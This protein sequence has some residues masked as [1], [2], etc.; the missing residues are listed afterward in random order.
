MVRMTKLGSLIA[1]LLVVSGCGSL[2]FHAVS[3]T[4]TATTVHRTFDQ[5]N[6]P[7]ECGRRQPRSHLNHCGV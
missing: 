5:L 1:F 7:D 3:T 6:L 4:A 2:K